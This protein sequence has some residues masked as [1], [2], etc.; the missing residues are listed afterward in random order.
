MAASLLSSSWRSIHQR[1][2]SSLSQYL[3]S[4]GILLIV[5]IILEIASCVTLIM[6]TVR[7]A[8]QCL[9]FA[10][11]YERKRILEGSHKVWCA[12][13]IF[14]HV[15]ALGSALLFLFWFIRRGKVRGYS[16]FFNA[17]ALLIASTLATFIAALVIS[18]GFQALCDSFVINR[19]TDLHFDSMDWKK[20][21]PQ[22]CDCDKG[23]SL[24]ESTMVCSWCSCF[25]FFLLCI[26]HALRAFTGAPP[27]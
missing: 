24:L 3:S 21:T 10:K 9:L 17:L 7:C 6:V 15:I 22:Y 4:D 8:G 20:F 5:A 2:T 27:T 19:C 14:L 25:I 13:P 11:I 12:L 16:N 18:R 1:I 26:V 23:Y